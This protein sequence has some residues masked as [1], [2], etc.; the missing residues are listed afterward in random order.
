MSTFI[1]D[2]EQT[3]NYLYLYKIYTV[4]VFFIYFWAFT[5]AVFITLE[6]LLSNYKLFLFP[7][8]LGLSIAFGFAIN[9]HRELLA[10]CRFEYHKRKYY[11]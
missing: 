3:E 10:D 7:I 1:K 9:I 11:K 2:A 4:G 8:G 5:T 6:L